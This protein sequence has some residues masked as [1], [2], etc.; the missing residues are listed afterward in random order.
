VPFHGFRR[1][2][3]SLVSIEQNVPASPGVYGIANAEEW[4]FI[5]GGDDVRDALLAHLND[6]R[7]PVWSRVP[8]GFVFEPCDS[9]E[10]S[11][12]LSRLKMELKPT[13]NTR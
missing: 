2:A 1:Y 10:Q 6:V 4:I 7:T 12:R 3:F 11:A 9:R 13:C 5:G 8:T